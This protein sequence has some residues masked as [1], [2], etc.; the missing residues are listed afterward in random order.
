MEIPWAN[1]IFTEFGK[2]KRGFIR[3]K[4]C[5]DTRVRRTHVSH[6]IGRCMTRI[7]QHGRIQECDGEYNFN[8]DVRSPNIWYTAHLNFF[9]MSSLTRPMLMKSGSHSGPSK[10]AGC[11]PGSQRTHLAE[12]GG[13]LFPEKAERTF[14][15]V[16]SGYALTLKNY[17][18]F[19]QSVRRMPDEDQVMRDRTL[20]SSSISIRCCSMRWLDRVPIPMLQKSWMLSSSV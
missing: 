2:C 3:D 9:C 4:E 15:L 20:F 19:L 11:S 13:R 10:W 7:S 14:S 12:W 8:D 6:S 18:N 1:S 17:Q 16:T 5:F